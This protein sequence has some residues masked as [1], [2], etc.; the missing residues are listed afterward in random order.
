MPSTLVSLSAACV[1]AAPT[2]VGSAEAMLA[3]MSR[4]VP[5]PSFS[6]VSVSATC[7]PQGGQVSALCAWV[8]D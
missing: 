2:L 6:S 4:E 1:S 3:K 8:E 5:L 7:V